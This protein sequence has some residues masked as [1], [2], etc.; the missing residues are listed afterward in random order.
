[1]L[2]KIRPD[3]MLVK[4]VQSDNHKF[5]A[6]MVPDKMM[7]YIL[8]EPHERLGHPGSV[9]LYLFLRKI[10]ATVKKGFTRHV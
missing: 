10:L 1:M 7:K 8:H 2:Y 9:K 3:H 4:I 6:I 5:E